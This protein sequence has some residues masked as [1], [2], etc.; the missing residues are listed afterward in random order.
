ML[1]STSAWKEKEKKERERDKDIL[2]RVICVSK[3]SVCRH[4]ALQE[5]KRG[6]Q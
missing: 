4:F 6:T 1:P 5:V 3:L 2:K